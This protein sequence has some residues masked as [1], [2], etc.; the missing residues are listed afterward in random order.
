MNNQSNNGE[1]FK[2]DYILV[3]ISYVI[4]SSL[5][6]YLGNAGLFFSNYVNAAAPSNMTASSSIHQLNS[7]ISSTNEYYQNPY[8][9]KESNR[10]SDDNGTKL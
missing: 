5:M 3:A 8:Y 10:K 2:S 6:I 4:L 9:T 1:M 7:S